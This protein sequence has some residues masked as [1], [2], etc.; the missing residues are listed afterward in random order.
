MSWGGC[1]HCEVAA[2]G[3]QYACF[4]CCQLLP[5]LWATNSQQRLCGD[6]GC[7]PCCAAGVML[8]EGS[9][10]W[11][12]QCGIGCSQLL[13]ITIGDEFSTKV[14]LRRWM[15]AMMLWCNTGRRKSL[16]VQSLWSCAIS[17]AAMPSL[18]VVSCPAS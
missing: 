15:L 6:N 7:L 5:L 18:I 2:Q 12:G 1:G 13:H 11:C 8:R 3:L 14:E 16:F 10:C 4:G 9:P 17:T